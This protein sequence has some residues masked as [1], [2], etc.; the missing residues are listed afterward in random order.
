MVKSRLHRARLMVRERVAPHLAD[1]GSGAPLA[2]RA[3]P[4]AAEPVPGCRDVVELFSRRLEGEIDAGACAAL[5]GYLERCPRCRGRCES[6]RTTLTMCK[7]AG[8]AQVPEDVARS[9][10]DAL[11][12]LALPPLAAR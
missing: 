1:G 10:R 6:L 3:T 12:R 5:E 7:A 11:R 9:V 4:A 8:A 2:A